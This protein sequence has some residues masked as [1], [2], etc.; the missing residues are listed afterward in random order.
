MPFIGH[1]SHVI[2]EPHFYQGRMFF[3]SLGDFWV[4]YGSMHIKKGIVLTLE[5]SDDQLCS[6][7]WRKTKCCC[8]GD[9]VLIS[10]L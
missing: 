5:F 6:L 2:H 3:S 8:T 9:S 10:F 1:H 4:S 7:E